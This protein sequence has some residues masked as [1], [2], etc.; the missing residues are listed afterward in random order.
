MEPDRDDA[1]V[2]R[3]LRALA[4]RVGGEGRA[5]DLAQ[6][7][8]LA[9]LERPA[10]RGSLRAWL[11]AILRNLARATRRGEGRRARR[12]LLAA[13]RGVAPA[14]AEEAA[15]AEVLARLSAAVR[16]LPDAQRRTVLRHFFDGAT[17]AEI[18]RGERVPGSTVRNRL[19]RA[20][21]ALRARLNDAAPAIALVVPARR[22][23]LTWPRMAAAAALLAGAAYASAPDEPDPPPSP[24]V[25]ARPATPTS[26]AGA[27]PTDIRP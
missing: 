3:W 17:L 11:A 18:A 25:Q 20:L 19:R 22:P 5:D 7:T 24:A 2:A 21:A 6:E 27:P 26:P 4:A 13:R 16:E 14:A 8:L 23:R 15:A 12:E 9:W 10:P 1:Q